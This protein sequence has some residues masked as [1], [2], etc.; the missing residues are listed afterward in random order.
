MIHRRG[1]MEGNFGW[2]PCKVSYILFSR[3]AEFQR[4]DEHDPQIQ[5]VVFRRDKMVL[6]NAGKAKV[7]SYRANHSFFNLEC[8]R[9]VDCDEN[10][11]DV[12]RFDNLMLVNAEGKELGS[13]PT[14]PEDVRFDYC[15]DIHIRLEL[16]RLYSMIAGTSSLGTLRDAGF[17]EKWTTIVFDPPQSNGGDG[18]PPD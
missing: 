9:I 14:N 11:A 7:E 8:A 1:N 12:L 2:V 15:M 16:A 6:D 13:R 5:P 4:P 18:G 3:G 17:I 10:T